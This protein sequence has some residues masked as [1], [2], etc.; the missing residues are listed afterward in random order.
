MFVLFRTSW[1]N[2]GTKLVNSTGLS[3]FFLNLYLLFPRSVYLPFYF[4]F[5][6]Y[7]SS[8]LYFYRSLGLGYWMSKQIWNNFVADP[9]IFINMEQVL[10]LWENWFLE[11]LNIN[12]FTLTILND[13][14]LLI[15]CITCVQTDYLI[16]F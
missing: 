2:K 6:F 12:T 8:W 14:I 13:S 15:F 7:L 10:G 4:Y 3:S 11:I 1:K 5:Y 9:K 16:C